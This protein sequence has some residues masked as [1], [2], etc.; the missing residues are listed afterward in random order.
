[1]MSTQYTASRDS[2]TN[3]AI[4]EAGYGRG[5]TFQS[6]PLLERRKWSRMAEI[7]PHSRITIPV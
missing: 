3:K 6:T 2:G 4:A 5:E 1:M 7:T